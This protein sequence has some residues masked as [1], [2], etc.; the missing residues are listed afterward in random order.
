M[1]KFPSIEKK[2]EREIE[3]LG[4]GAL[5]RVERASEEKTDHYAIAGPY[6]ERGRSDAEVQRADGAQRSR[7]AHY[8]KDPASSLYDFREVQ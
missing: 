4:R 7:R 8:M 6:K 3:V 1:R 2:E 5:S